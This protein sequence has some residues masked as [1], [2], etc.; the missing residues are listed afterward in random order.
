VYAHVC[1]CVWCVCVGVWVWCMCVCCVCVVCLCIACVCV[2]GACVCVCVCV[3]VAHNELCFNVLFG[4]V[5]STLPLRYRTLCC[6]RSATKRTM[7]FHPTALHMRVCVLCFY[8]PY[9]CGV[10]CRLCVCVCVCACS[11]VCVLC[12]MYYAVECVAM[13]AV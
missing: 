13:C 8:G 12:V 3:C 9:V 5:E 11:T 4:V 7:L 6:S 1:V 2:G 10:S